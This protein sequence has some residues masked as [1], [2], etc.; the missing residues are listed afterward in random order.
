MGKDCQSI[1]ITQA[2]TYHF[3]AKVPM[4]LEQTIALSQASH[5]HKDSIPKGRDP[6]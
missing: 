1:L 5:S 6:D 3:K 2:N 4:G